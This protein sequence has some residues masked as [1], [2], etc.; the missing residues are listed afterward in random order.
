M[1]LKQTKSGKVG[2]HERVGRFSVELWENME[3]YKSGSD[4]RR[5][6]KNDVGTIKK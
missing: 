3:Y 5:G 6:R 2:L 4:V 1:N